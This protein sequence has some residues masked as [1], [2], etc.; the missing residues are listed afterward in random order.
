V[1]SK[2]RE[3]NGEC[4]QEGCEKSAFWHGIIVEESSLVTYEF[5]T[6]NE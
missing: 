5:L 6:C 3:I 1:F 2:R 4:L